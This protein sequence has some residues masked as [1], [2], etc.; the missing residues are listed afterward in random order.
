MPVQA[1]DQT[2][3][4]D[5]RSG[6][7][8]ALSGSSRAMADAGAVE[9]TVRLGDPVPWFGGPLLGQGSFHLQVAAGRWIVLAFLDPSRPG[10]FEHELE[11]LIGGLR[12]DDDHV[13]FCG[14]L[15]VPPQHP[16]RL[17]G[18]SNGAVNF[19]A[20]YD[21][22]IGRLFGAIEKPR[23]FVLDP[24]LRAV[25]NIPADAPEG[26][27]KAVREVVSSLPK[28]DESAGVPLTAPLLIV[29]RVFDFP[30]CETL[31]RVFNELGGAESGFLLD[32]N[33]KTG[34]VIDHRLK[35]RSDLGIS[36]PVLR[37]AMRSQIVR[38]LI[39][40]VDRFF[41]FKATRLDRYI[42]SCYD[43]ADG[44][45]FRRHR[46]NENIGGQHRRFAITIN[47][48]KDYQGGDLVFAEFGRRSYRAP[49][50][51]AIVFSCGALHQV[52]PVVTGRR[53]A[54]LAFLYGEAD[55]ALRE[56]N[57]AKLHPDAARYVPESDLL[58]PDGTQQRTG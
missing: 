51:G 14:V 6:A 45:H 53:Y 28:V 34:R 3:A 50:G 43:A 7:R 41:Q 18:R 32:L 55:A 4:A 8:R 35:R 54:C 16:E 49:V 12:F 26:H 30:L 25:A 9:T 20:D 1:I 46:D 29:P 19:I 23:T 44:G 39:P 42:V 36:H 17:I 22:A 52:T 47:L 11:E 58:F 37:E 24:L 2:D 56:A 10:A 5:P 13:I 57:N 33:G 48:N 40:A 15:A 27:G 21:G 38:R 31:I